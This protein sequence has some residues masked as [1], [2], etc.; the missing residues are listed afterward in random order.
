MPT[1]RVTIQPAYEHNEAMPIRAV[2]TMPPSWLCEA[3]VAAVQ[4]VKEAAAD[5]QS[6]RPVSIPVAEALMWLDALQQ[7]TRDVGR[8]REE[9]KVLTGDR[10]VRALRFVRGRTHHHWAP[11][12]YFDGNVAEWVWQPAENL[13]LPPEERFLDPK[14]EKLYEELLARKP[15]LPALDEVAR[16]L[17][18]LH[19][20]TETSASLAGAP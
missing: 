5:T 18:A 4:R 13:P 11:T 20:C 7:T 9:A 12:A 8:G 15:V 19:L 14:G 16:K 3:Y 6:A 1:K 17:Q 2:K 10:L